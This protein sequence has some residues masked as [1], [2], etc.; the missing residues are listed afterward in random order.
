MRKITIELLL[1]ESH[2]LSAQIKVN[3]FAEETR[4]LGKCRVESREATLEE[5]ATFKAGEQASITGG[6]IPP[7]QRSMNRQKLREIVLELDKGSPE[8][9]GSTIEKLR[10]LGAVRGIHQGRTDLE[11]KPEE[12]VEWYAGQLLD[13]L[14]NKAFFAVNSIINCLDKFVPETT[15]E[16]P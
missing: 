13:V 2:H 1:P 15:G 10:E 11:G 6:P 8:T 4:F 12:I 14:E 3:R 5:I 7:R 16:Q 9:S